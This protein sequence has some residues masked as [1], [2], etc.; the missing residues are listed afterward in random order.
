MNSWSE[1]SAYETAFLLC[2]A[3]QDEGKSFGLRDF[4][5]ALPVELKAECFTPERQAFARGWRDA[6]TFN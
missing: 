4:S 5:E 2:Q 1:E 6:R 3:R